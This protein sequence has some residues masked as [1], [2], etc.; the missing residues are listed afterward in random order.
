[1]L[2]KLAI[3]ITVLKTMD[4]SDSVHD[5]SNPQST[6]QNMCRHVYTDIAVLKPELLS[7]IWCIIAYEII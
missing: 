4:Y 1:M 7:M 6:K 5:L 3:D 2:L